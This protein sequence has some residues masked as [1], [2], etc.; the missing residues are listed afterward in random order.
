MDGLLVEQR[1]DG[2]AVVTIDRP[3]RRNALD[4]PLLLEGLPGA[5]ADLGADPSVRAIVVT[6]SGGAFC[7]GADLE[8]SGLEQPSAAASERFMHKS[9][10]TV[11]NIRS[12]RQP[13]IAAVDG[14]AVGAGAGL[15]AACDIRIASRRARFITPFLKMALPPDYGSSYLLPRIVGPEVALDLFLTGRT[16]DGEEALRIGLVS[17]LA[18]DPLAAA[19]E[20]ATGIAAMPPE[21]VAV[22]KANVYHGLDTDMRSAIFDGEIRSV[23]IALH[24]EEFGEAF[25]AWRKQIRG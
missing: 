10:R 21:A 9:H 3:Q 20:L 7:A 14:A 8:C 15:A 22:T 2:V 4:D 12:A 19:L 24:G 6:G 17:R 18:D 11:M 5:F 16:V 1:E 23:A 25:A 13:V